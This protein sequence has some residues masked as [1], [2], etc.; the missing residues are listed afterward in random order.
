MT[1]RVLVSDKLSERGLDVFRNAGPEIELDARPGIGKKPDELMEIIGNYDALAIRSGTQVTPELI[2]RATK[3]KVVGRAGIGVDNINRE[4][5]SKNGIVVMNTPDGN[6]ITTAEHAISL[7][8]A[9]CRRI[10]QATAS[11]R[12][13]K[14]EKSKFQ[15]RELYGKNLGIIGLGNIGKVVADRALGLKMNVLAYDPFVTA[16]KAQALGV[17]LRSIDELLSQADIVTLHVPLLDATKNIIN[18]SALAKM[19]P[20]ALL[21]NAARGGLVDEAAVVE[22]LKTGQLGGAAFDVYETEP[23]AP[24]HPLL[25][26][27]QVILTPHLGASTTEAQDNVAVSVAHQII[28]FLKNGTVINAVNAPSVP[29]EVLAQIGPYIDLGRKLGC[30]AGQ[31]HEGNVHEIKMNYAGA[32]AEQ[33]V[34]PITVASLSSVLSSR[35]EAQVND[36]NAPHIAKD[37]GIVCIEEKTSTAT[38]FVATVSLTLRGDDGTTEVT[39]AV[40]GSKDARIVALNGRRLE[41]LPIGHLLLTKHRDEPGV[42]GRIGNVLGSGN[43]NISRMM[44]GVGE[45]F[46]YAAI[47]V[48]GPVSSVVLSEIAHLDGIDNVRPINF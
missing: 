9:L 38:D 2:A 26:L 24:D 4:A 5:A 22:A 44:L 34:D 8:C 17:K 31:F 23:P 43:I 19:K 7:M 27:E 48:D 46:A 35:L 47:S 30:F 45:K 42:I 28:D 16:E 13:G 6:V 40:F 15:G 10:P 32:A 29:A 3:L 18:A 12:A 39:G 20:G 1:F 37:R 25:G 14:W 36:I 41:V 33:R 11:M 21:I